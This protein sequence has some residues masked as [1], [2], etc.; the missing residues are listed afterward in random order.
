M[1]AWSDGGGD[2]TQEEKLKMMALIAAQAHLHAFFGHLG[3]QHHQ[4]ES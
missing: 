2:R 1:R 4:Q 3:G